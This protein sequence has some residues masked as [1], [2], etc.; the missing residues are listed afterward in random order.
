MYSI[1]SEQADGL[2]E[3]RC[4]LSHGR[5][6]NILSPQLALLISPG[7]SLYEIETGQMQSSIALTDKGHPERCIY[8]TRRAA[9]PP[10]LLGTPSGWIALSFL[11][12][13]REGGWKDITGPCRQQRR[14][15]FLRARPA[16]RTLTEFWSPTMRNLKWNSRVA[17]EVH[18][19]SW[20]SVEGGKAAL[21]W[22]R[23]IKMET[24]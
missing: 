15:Y 20:Q 14:P 8:V 7:I 10:S 13:D 11:Q 2:G 6:L 17:R 18:I 23:L 21:R 9:I 24:I 12:P 1:I 16:E 22:L 5:T 3:E 4:K 19:G